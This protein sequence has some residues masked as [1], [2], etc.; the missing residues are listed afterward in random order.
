MFFTVLAMRTPAGGPE[1]ALEWPGLPGPTM[2]WLAVKAERE[3][4]GT[5]GGGGL[6][7][8]CRAP[9]GLSRLGRRGCATAE[10]G[11]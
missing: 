6:S 2:N 4:A 7:P 11:Q 10:A 3:A 5:A 1:L 8:A 9:D